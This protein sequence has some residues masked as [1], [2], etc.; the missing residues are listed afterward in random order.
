MTSGQ[1]IY[2]ITDNFSIA[3]T[4]V[5]QKGVSSM[6]RKIRMIGLFCWK[7]EGIPIISFDSY[8]KARRYRSQL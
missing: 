3:Y 2:T 5:S 8:W 4:P 7:I 1:Y 6:K